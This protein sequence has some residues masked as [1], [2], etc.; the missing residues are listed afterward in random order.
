MILISHR[1]NIEGK[2][3]NFENKPDYIDLDKDGNKTEPM[4]KAAKDKE[5]KKVKEHGQ[6]NSF[7][8][9]GCVGEMKK[10]FASG[11]IPRSKNVFFIH[12]Q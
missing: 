12:C 10:L 5:N 11:C 2:N 3:V 4:K 7:D 8:E 1:G 9:A 6:D